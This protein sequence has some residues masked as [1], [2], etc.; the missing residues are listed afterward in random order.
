MIHHMVVVVIQ[1]RVLT[2]SNLVDLLDCVFV[3]IAAAFKY[4]CPS[5]FWQLFV[6]FKMNFKL[7][8]HSNLI[9]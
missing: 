4:F 8:Y 2:I 5:S 7:D 6:L 1:L 9:R 3:T